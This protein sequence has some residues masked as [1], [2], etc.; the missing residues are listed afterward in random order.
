MDWVEVSAKR[1][2]LLVMSIILL[3]A[4]VMIFVAAVL[5][6]L[7]DGFKQSVNSGG[8]Q[9]LYHTD[10][11]AVFQACQIVLADP[12]KAG[13]SKLQNGLSDMEGQQ[14]G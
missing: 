6:F 12:Q 1:R 13:F 3:V 10:N 11:A 14:A 2:Q 4:A 8:E 7:F 9:L 5:S